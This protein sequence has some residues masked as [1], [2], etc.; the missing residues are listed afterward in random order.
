MDY[1]S[2]KYMSSLVCNYPGVVSK[3]YGEV[4]WVERQVVAPSRGK[5]ELGSVGQ[6]IVE[7]SG[8]GNSVGWGVLLNYI[9]EV[10]EYGI[11]DSVSW[12][13]VIITNMK[14]TPF[15]TFYTTVHF[16]YVSG[17]Q[18]RILNPPPPWCSNQT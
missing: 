4:C 6:G 13:C 14:R 17:N 2:I 7:G 3:R 16:H 18:G 12:Q 11:E 10:T 9:L 1:S 8:V 15:R 5:A